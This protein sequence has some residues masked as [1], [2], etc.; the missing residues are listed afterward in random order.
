MAN[1]AV[2][3]K[4]PLWKKLLYTTV[5]L[6]SA[7]LLAESVLRLCGYGPKPYWEVPVPTTVGQRKINPLEYFA[8]C[9]RH[10]GFRNR[11]NGSY[12]TWYVDGNPL[13]TTDEFGYRNGF[14]WSADGESP[15]VLFLGDSFTFCA[16][17]VDEQTGPSEVA[18]LLG[19]ETDVRVLNAGVRGYSTVQSKRMLIESLERFAEIKVAVYTFCGNDIGENIVP[20]LRYPLKA[21]M[22]IRDPETGKFRET[23]VSEPAVPWGEGFYGWEAPQPVLSTGEKVAN[24]VET[25]SVLCH[26]CLVGWR[27]ITF[28]LFR[29]PEF[30][31]GKRVVPPSDYPKWHAWAAKNGGYEVLQ[32]LLAE[33]DQV[34]RA[35]GAAFVVTGAIGGTNLEGSKLLSAAC[36]AKC[37][38]VDVQFVSIESQF[39]EDFRSYS[40]LRVDGQYD[41]HYGPPGTKAYARGLAPALKRILRSQ[42]S[43]SAA[44]AGVPGRD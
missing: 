12:R 19:E 14:G 41:G 35:H 18:R 25:R 37:A 21:P 17:V 30:P 6:V 15:I 38:A 13:V 1:S 39:T 2:R 31:D 16:E 44:D 42:A 29:Q 8:V 4:L 7:L 5:I 10:L 33:M 11:A 24:W 43:V 20:N 28:G 27:Q 40:C 23:E 3:K 34:C 9:D 22:M 32:G 26:R 36:A